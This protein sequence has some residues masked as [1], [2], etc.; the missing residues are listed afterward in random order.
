[1]S[2][3]RFQDIDCRAEASDGCGEGLE[4]AERLAGRQEKL[5]TQDV[6]D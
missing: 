5:R 1:M 6:L 3:C 2:G 4:Q